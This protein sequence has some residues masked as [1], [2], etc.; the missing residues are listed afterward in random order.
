MAERERGIGVVELVIALLVA[1]GV[2][3]IILA[4]LRST[5]ETVKTVTEQKPQAQSRLLADRGTAAALR[6]AVSIYFGRE[7]KFPPDKA[8]VDALVSPPPAFQCP[9]NTYT[10]DPATGKITLA[11]NDLAGC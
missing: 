3:A 1:A 11:I 6:G 10:Y 5:E 2:V 7:G 9:G 4:Y 8:A